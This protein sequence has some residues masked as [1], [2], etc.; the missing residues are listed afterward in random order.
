ML[1]PVVI[2]LTLAICP[3]HV[4]TVG[5]IHLDE[6]VID[7]EKKLGPGWRGQV[8]DSVGNR[9]TAL[10]YT[11][12]VDQLQVW[13]QRERG[14]GETVEGIVARENRPE[15]G[16]FAPRTPLRLWR[17]AGGTLFE[18]PDALRGWRVTRWSPPRR[19]DGEVASY[20]CADGT[21]VWFTKNAWGGVDIHLYAD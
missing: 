19:F 4:D 13:L 5:P 18:M 15:G 6:P 1:A 20:E 16:A 11:D 2:A 7:V 21:T 10:V 3:A 9:A 14:F 8:F 12:G 17:W